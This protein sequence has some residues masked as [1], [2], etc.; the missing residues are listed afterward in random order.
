HNGISR[1]FLHDI[2]FEEANKLGVKYRMG[3]R[4]ATLDQ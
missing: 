4:V 1:K 2:L 3:V